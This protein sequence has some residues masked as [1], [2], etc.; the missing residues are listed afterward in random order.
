V[1][2]VFGYCARSNCERLDA[3]RMPY[4]YAYVSDHCPVVV[5]L[6]DVDRD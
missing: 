4:D 6:M 1:A 5:D 2:R 3:D